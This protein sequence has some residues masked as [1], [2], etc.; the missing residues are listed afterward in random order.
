[1]ALWIR[2]RQ[3]GLG[4]F[5]YDITKLYEPAANHEKTPDR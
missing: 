1:M 4:R 2:A 5:F 3:F